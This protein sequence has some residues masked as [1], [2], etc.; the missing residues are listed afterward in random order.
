MATSVTPR[1]WA[2]TAGNRQQRAFP[3]QGLPAGTYDLRA[4]KQGLGT[5]VYGAEK[6]REIGETITLADGESRVG[7]KLRFIHSATISGRVLDSDG[8]PIDNAMVTVLRPGRQLGE[9]ILVRGMSTNTNDRGEYR[10]SNMNPGQYYLKADPLPARMMRQNGPNDATDPGPHL[11]E[12][13]QFLGGAREWTDATP[14]TIR[15]G[16]N[17]TGL[18]FRITSEP[19]AHLMG[20]VTGVPDLGPPPARPTGQVRMFGDQP[21]V[22]I[23][24]S[25]I[26]Q[27]VLQWS[28]GAG[29]SPPDYKFDL[30]EQ[31]PGRYRLDASVTHEKKT[32]SASQIVDT[33]QTS[34]E[35]TLALA[36][37][38]DVK[39]HFTLEGQAARPKGGFTV[40]LVT[41][42]GFRRGTNSAQVGADGN[43][44]LTQVEPGEWNVNIDTIPR[45]GFLKSMRLGD[46]D[47]TFKPLEIAPGSDAPLNIVVSMNSSKID[48]E[49]DAAG[50][51]DPKRAA[52][53]LAPMGDRHTL[54]R[55]YYSINAD[56]S[57]KFKMMG[58]APGKYKIF[59]LEKMTAPEFRTPEAADLLEPLGEEIELT[60][61]GSLT[62]HP[63]LIPMERAREALP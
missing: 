10:L 36:P 12:V 44:T 4:N 33:R 48:G 43:F 59:A 29:A 51:G 39:G 62:W 17:L 32:Y 49:V 53:L 6:L 25:P 1:S 58:L 14:L 28:G 21:F 15:G 20:H 47:V 27:G 19:V 50:A 40:R 5:A 60:E 8:D 31:V 45:L 9:R 18:D 3:V 30:G 7:V 41:G 38:V 63:K 56:D 2:T 11:R 16:E 26:D 52:I 35:I 37:A 46:K 24:M 57:G 34:G 55:F 54:A 61:G 22:S 23:Q 42:A 13:P